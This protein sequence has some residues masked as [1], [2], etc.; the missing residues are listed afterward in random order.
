[1]AA[2]IKPCSQQ[3]KLW[4]SKGTPLDKCVCWEACPVVVSF[5]FFIAGPDLLIPWKEGEDVFYVA[6][7]R[8]EWKTKS[9]PESHLCKHRYTRTLPVSECRA[10][11]KCHRIIQ[12]ICRKGKNVM[13]LSPQYVAQSKIVR[14]SVEIGAGENI[15]R[16]SLC[17]SV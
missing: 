16:M 3:T 17:Q 11:L 8:E 6:F 12:Q 15:V 10:G 13:E 2:F 14:N 1:M 5:L 9:L 7:Y 4:K